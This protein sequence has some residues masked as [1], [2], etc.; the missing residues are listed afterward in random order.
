MKFLTPEGKIVEGEPLTETQIAQRA[1]LV[2]YLH[3]EACANS[4][5]SGYERRDGVKCERIANFFITKFTI[6][7][8]DGA[9]LRLNPVEEKEPLAIEAP[10]PA[11]IPV[12]R[13]AEDSEIDTSDIP[14]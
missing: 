6:T 14:F 10:T 8:L 11:E 13:P 12:P 9:T 3:H 1:E 7:P 5:H 2:E 4:Y